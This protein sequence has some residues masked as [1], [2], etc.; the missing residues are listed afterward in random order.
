[1]QSITCPFICS[2]TGRLM[3]PSPSFPLLADPSPFL[4]SRCGETVLFLAKLCLVQSGKEKR[5]QWKN[6]KFKRLKLFSYWTWS[7]ILIM[8]TVKYNRKRRECVASHIIISF[9]YYNDCVSNHKGNLFF[10]T[11]CHWSD[12]WVLLHPIWLR[13]TNELMYC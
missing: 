3:L 2:L 10:P 12:E 7:S 6:L 13:V 8:I 9:T 1:M 11:T 5:T 4:F